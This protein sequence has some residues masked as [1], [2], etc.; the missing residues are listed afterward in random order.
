VQHEVTEYDLQLTDSWNGR[1]GTLTATLKNP[2]GQPVEGATI[3]F[4]TGTSEADWDYLNSAVTDAS[5]I[6]TYVT[7]DLTVGTYNFIARFSVTQTE[8]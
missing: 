6:A 8:S 3:Q 5:G 1:L 7:K 4:G 2:A